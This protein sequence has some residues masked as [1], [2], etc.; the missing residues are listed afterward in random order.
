MQSVAGTVPL[1]RYWNPQVGDH[2]YTTDWNELGNGNYGW[3]F[4][5]VQCYVHAQAVP[6]T[7]PLYRYWNSQDGDHFYTTDWN[8]LGNG[9]YGWGYEGIQCY[10]HDQPVLGQPIS[11]S[12][13]SSAPAL[14][15]ATFRL[16]L[17]TGGVQSPASPSPQPA[18][19]FTGPGGAGASPNVPGTFGGVVRATGAG[20]PSSFVLT[21]SQGAPGETPSIPATFSLAGRS[22]RGLQ[23]QD[24]GP[25]RVVVSIDVNP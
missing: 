7:V 3:S 6:G 21:R 14:I 8:E 1:Y 18:S 24:G 5:R 25:G 9:N 15:P 22:E 12:G 17:G 13:A 20:V 16:A 11:S 4:E 23:G 19:S 2:F 10:V